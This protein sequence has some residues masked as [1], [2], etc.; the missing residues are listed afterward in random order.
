MMIDLYPEAG[1]N[2][3]VFVSSYVAFPSYSCQIVRQNKNKNFWCLKDRNTF[4]LQ[5]AVFFTDSFFLNG[6]VHIFKMKR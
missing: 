5:Y 2:P 4:H 3:S 6:Q 1:G